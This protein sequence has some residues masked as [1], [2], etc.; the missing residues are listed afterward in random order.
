MDFR[1]NLSALLPPH[2]DDEPASLRQDILDELDDH[3]ACAVQ[4]R[5]CCVDWIQICHVSMFWNDSA[6]RRPLHTGSGSMR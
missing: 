5:S 2:R 4:P 6:I 1:D 3:L